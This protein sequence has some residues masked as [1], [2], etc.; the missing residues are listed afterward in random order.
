VTG[1]VDRIEAAF[2]A[3]GAEAY[4]GERV[5]MSEH[6]LQAAATAQQWGAPDSVV[7]AA[8]LHDIGHL[9]N[10]DLTGAQAD[11]TVLEQVDRVHESVGAEWLAQGFG[12]EVTEP[13]RLHVAAKRYLCATEPEYLAALSAAS[14]HTLGL[15][16]GPMSATEAEAFSALPFAEHAVLLRRCDDAGKRVGDATPTL[17]HFLPLVR[18]LCH[19]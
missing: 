17:E 12:P 18:T 4:L 9:V 16:G 13:V 10:D 8:L 14:V 15:Q 11:P 3:R 5:S 2:R 6:M 19:G 7:V 1:F